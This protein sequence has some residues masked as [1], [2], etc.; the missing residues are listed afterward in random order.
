[1]QEYITDAIV[2]DA[3]PNGDCDLRIVLFTKEFGKLTPKAKS[4]RKTVSKLNGHLQ[5]GNLVQARLVEKNGLHVV[6]VLAER[7]LPAIP[8]ELH[9]LGKILGEGE[10][11]HA[12]WRHLI[13]GAMD[14]RTVLRILGWDPTDARCG[15]CGGAPLA[16]HPGQQE[17]FCKPC[18]FQFPQG[19]LIF[20]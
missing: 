10:P 1:M 20:I 14:W 9:V 15:Q 17:F 18:A 8:P 4:A 19:T 13:G 11:D 2:L 5:P 3:E 7:R 6:D 12:L 16:F